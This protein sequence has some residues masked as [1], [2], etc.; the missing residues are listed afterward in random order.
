MYFFKLS[1]LLASIYLMGCSAAYEEVKKINTDNPKTFQEYILFNYQENASFEAEE[2]HDWNSA[3]LYSE[4]ALRAFNGDYIYPEK[5]ENWEIP[6]NKIK[7]IEIAYNNLISIYEEAIIYDPKNLAKAISSLDCWAEQEEEEWQTWDIERCKN[8]HLIAMHNI[9]NNLS[10]EK[11]EQKKEDEKSQKKEIKS[12]IAIVTQNEKKELMQIIYFDFDDFSLSDISLITL[13][14]FLAKNKKDLSRF[15]IVGHTDTK[16]S[17]DYNLVLSLKRA[18]VVK[19][20]LIS[21]GISEKN[22]SVLGQGEDNSAINTPDNTK[23]PANRRAEIK[24]LN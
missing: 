10:K 1:L 9:Y 8:N 15:I 3:K 11:K 22:I 6:K 5:I 20:I 23:H 17:N 13:K 19:E 4:K 12:Q 24:I 18:E 2:M 14:K 21:T 7:E 16:G